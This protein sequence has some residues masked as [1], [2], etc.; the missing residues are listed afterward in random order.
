MIVEKTAIEETEVKFEVNHCRLICLTVAVMRVCNRM[1][2][3]RDTIHISKQ[4][5]C[6]GTALAFNRV[7]TNRNE[8][9]CEFKFKHC[10]I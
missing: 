7:Q 8:S 4:L 6:S 10:K 9:H 5:L 1:N 3:M 2:S